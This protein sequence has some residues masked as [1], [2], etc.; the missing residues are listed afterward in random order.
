MA[1]KQTGADLKDQFR[2]LSE[3]DI[4]AST[5]EQSYQKGYTYYLDH[6]IIEPTLSDSVL[7]AFCHG[8]E[9]NPYR[10]EATLLP[11]SE[12]SNRKLAAT[13]CSCPRGGFCKHLVALLL[14]W[15]HQ[16]ESFI[17]RSGLMA[18]LSMKT[19]EELVA[20]LEELLRRQYDIQS[21]VEMLIELPL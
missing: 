13:N 10:V 19:H 7:R 8:S 20:L 15:L 4:Q 18:R 9:R 6:N 12:T 11:A 17:V 1:Q 14:T 2:A 21:L 16:P 5:N 3:A